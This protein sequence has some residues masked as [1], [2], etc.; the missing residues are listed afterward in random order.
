MTTPVRN[1]MR[2]AA[3]AAAALAT[4]A[5]AFAQSI[6]TGPLAAVPFGNPWV[7]VALGLSL[8]AGMYWMLQRRERLPRLAMLGVGLL[9]AGLWL[10]S[11]LGAQISSSFT[12]PAGSTLAI[13]V[14]QKTSGSDVSGFEAADFVNA[15]GAPLLVTAI[16]APTFSECF[17]GGLDGR[18]LPPG[19]SDPSPP[20]ACAVNAP[21]AAGA[22]CRVDVEAIC[23]AAAA[24]NLATL[25]SV[26]PVSG[27]T[28]GGTAV[29]ITGTNLTGA[30]GVTFGGAAAT[31]V[32][33]VDATTVTATTPAH[34][35]GA[36]DVVVTTP[37]GSPTLAGG[38][39][40]V[41]MVTLTAV[42]ADSGTA[43]G[44]TG[45]A[46]TGTN[47]T[48]TTGVTF[49]GVAATSVN[50]V[51]A[52]TV[53]A[54]TPA[55]AAGAVDV[56]ITT[57]SGSATLSNGYTYVATA[58][59]QPSGGGVIAGLGGGLQNLIAAAADN[60][61]GV[62]WGGADTVT[63]AQS[64]TDGAT[65]TTTIVAA[66]GTGTYAAAVCAN[67]EVDSQGNVPCESGNACYDDW[68]LPALDQLNALYVNRAAIGAFASA[69]YYS[70]TE[71]F[72]SPGIGAMGQSLDSG[73]QFAIYKGSSGRVRCVRGFTP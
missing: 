6:T 31:A 46:L 14:T 65:N 47:L 62:E 56:V 16:D 54:V 70:S 71:Y 64:A 68:F 59:G 20:P 72:G 33:V 52:T 42:T 50:V 49:G 4:P 23:R 12:N 18:L 61:T 38:Y 10:G 45:I 13:P 8:I 39:T 7:L 28:L 60:S 19:G 30:T 69:F 17:P 21:L 2:A 22:T 51:N 44:S 58:V 15:S 73:G 35:A 41:Q 43:S 5:P 48:G 66:L 53:T 55:H 27:T 37:A 63:S 9:G 29:T 34:A 25:A 57:A 67:Y 26:S 24:G 1:R 11:S 36:V 3:L 32:T 40:Y